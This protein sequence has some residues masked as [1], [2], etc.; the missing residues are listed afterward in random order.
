MRTIIFFLIIIFGTIW[1]LYETEQLHL[2]LDLE[3]NK[4]EWNKI[5][6]TVI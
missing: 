2:L 5:N 3:W 6:T 1:A 4:I